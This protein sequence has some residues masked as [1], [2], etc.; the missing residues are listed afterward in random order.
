[1][2]M[3]PLSIWDNK[4]DLV[5]YYNEKHHTLSLYVKG[6]HHNQRLDKSV[7]NQSGENKLCLMPARQK[8]TWQIAETFRLAHFYFTDQY[9][10]Q[11]ALETF[12]K[13][14]RDIH[15]KELTFQ[16]DEALASLLRFGIF[17]TDWQDA[18]NH[19]FIDN[20]VQMITLYILQQY[21]YERFST[22]ESFRRAFVKKPKDAARIYI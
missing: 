15:L 13:D 5:N 21:I 22:S 17:Q 14:P 2:R 11:T 7:T 12:D 19:H 18:Q 4:N 3:S 16:D 9:L 10:K 1:M 6:G 20:A 8:S